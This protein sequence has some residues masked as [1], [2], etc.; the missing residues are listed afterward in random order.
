MAS[1]FYEKLE[2][3]FDY[4][5]DATVTL[6]DNIDAA[7]TSRWEVIMD[8]FHSRRENLNQKN[9]LD[10]VYKPIEPEQLYLNKS[11][12][13]YALS[14]RAV[15]QFSPFPQTPGPNVKNAGST[16]GKNFSIERQTENINIFRSLAS[17]IKIEIEKK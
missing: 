4:L 9:R 6:D 15:V 2:T 8:Q 12:W 11:D 5:P 16:I 17:Y 10:S 3:I 14:S 7:R 13:N 1:I